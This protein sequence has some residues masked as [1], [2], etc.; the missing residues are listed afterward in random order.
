MQFA[1][2]SNG[3]KVWDASQFK[4]L[5]KEEKIAL[6]GTLTCS[7]CGESAWFR[8]A[9]KHG[10][11]AHFCARH[12]NG[13]E[14][15]TTSD[16]TDVETYDPSDIEGQ[17][18][19]SGRIVIHLDDESSDDMEQNA[20]ERRTGVN[21]GRRGKNFTGSYIGRLS[22]R[23]L[24]LSKILQHLIQNPDISRSDAMLVIHE[25][26]E[27]I[28]LEGEIRDLV[29]E[30]DA[31]TAEN[32]KNHKLIYWGQIVSAHYSGAGKLW[33]NTSDDRRAANICMNPGVA[34]KFIDKCDVQ[35]PFDLEDAFVLVIGDCWVAGSKK[36]VV[37]CNSEKYICVYRPR[38]K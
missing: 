27:K 37:W 19:S 5:S 21:T 12:T 17:I 6:R 9:S 7:A 13:C 1:S 35:D 11:A 14:N 31:V 20:K 18:R 25:S 10:Q 22:S 3:Q 24:T 16:S 26:A 33:L 15:R 28:L 4:K 32:Y 38:G 23:H 2:T 30:I 36:P 29:V 8:K 34:S